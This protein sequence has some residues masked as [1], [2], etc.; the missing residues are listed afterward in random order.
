MQA[1]TAGSF[2][3][4]LDTVQQLFAFLVPQHAQ[5]S[6]Q[7]AGGTSGVMPDQQEERAIEQHPPAAPV[8][9][10]LRPSRSTTL[11]T[12]YEKEVCQSTAAAAA[13][14]DQAQQVGPQAALSL[15]LATPI[16]AVEASAAPE[17]QSR[18]DSSRHRSWLHRGLRYVP[19]CTLGAH[20]PL[21][22]TSNHIVEHI[23]A[24]HQS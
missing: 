10:S 15:P 20:A 1:D 18:P 14:L 19:A 9:P 11:L 12:A 7:A 5:P 3:A 6:G 4:G 16:A 17:W 23:H 13:P 2:A 24:L 8:L 21:H 22:F